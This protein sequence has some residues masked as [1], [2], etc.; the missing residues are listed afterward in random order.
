MKTPCEL[1][2]RS[3]R[4]DPAGGGE[5]WLAAAEDGGVIKLIAKQL[6]GHHRRGRRP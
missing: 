4:A 1:R 2:R 6:D 3:L 5:L